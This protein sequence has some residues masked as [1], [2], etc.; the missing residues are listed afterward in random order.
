[1]II[2]MVQLRRKQAIDIIDG[3]DTE[4]LQ[5]GDEVVFKGWLA[6][7]GKHHLKSKELERCE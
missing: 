6:T 5:P 3:R 1:M 4:T 7:W 2:A